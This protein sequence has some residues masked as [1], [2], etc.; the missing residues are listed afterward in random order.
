MDGLSKRSSLW[1]RREVGD[2][3]EMARITWQRRFGVN[4]LSIGFD[5]RNEEGAAMN[6]FAVDKSPVRL[7]RFGRVYLP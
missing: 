7:S 6:G 3:I 1:L 4:Q 2:G 5:G